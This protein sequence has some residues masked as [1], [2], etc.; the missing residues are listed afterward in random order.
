METR[1]WAIHAEADEK[2]INLQIILERYLTRP[3]RMLIREPILLLI[4]MY[5]FPRNVLTIILQ[6]FAPCAN[7]S[8]TK[9]CWSCLW[10]P[11]PLLHCLSDFL[12]ARTGVGRSMF[13]FDPF[14]LPANCL[15][16]GPRWSSF[17]FSYN[18]R[19]SRGASQCLPLPHQICCC[20]RRLDFY[21]RN[22]SS[23]N[24]H[25]RLSSPPWSF[26]VGLGF[27]ARHALASNH[28]WSPHGSRHYAHPRK[29]F[30]LHRRRLSK[31]R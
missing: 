29:R 5:V 4:A 24:D 16:S 19:H 9:I 31:E 21:P 25:W 10:Y 14:S 2:T 17:P 12:S 23:P 11:I 20:P 28:R 1:N 30:K 3:Y 15:I 18:R 6:I 7:L 27:K 8:S 22:A 13:P 26:L